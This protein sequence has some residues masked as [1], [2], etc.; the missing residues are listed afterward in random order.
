MSDKFR[1]WAWRAFLIVITVFGTLLSGCGGLRLITEEDAPTYSFD[2]NSKIYSNDYTL[3]EGPVKGGSANIYASGMDSLNPLMTQNMYTREIMNLIYEGL[4]EMDTGLTARPLLADSSERSEDGLTWKIYIKENIQWHDGTELTSADVLYTIKRIQAYGDDCVYAPLL[5]N[6]ANVIPDGK[7]AI[8]IRLKKVNSFTLE[9][10]IFPIIPSH[11]EPRDDILD[12]GTP[13][14]E[15]LIGTGPY[16][17]GNYLPNES[18]SLYFNEDVS[19]DGEGVAFGPPYIQEI[20]FI[21]IE[22]E[23]SVITEFQ[24][25]KLDGFFSRTVGFEHYRISSDMISRSFSER[26]FE[27]IAFNLNR[28]GLSKVVRNA[29]ARIIDREAIIRDVLDGNGIVADFPVQPENWL[30]EMCAQ[31]ISRDVKS[32]I[33]S[34]ENGGYRLDFDSYSRPTSQGEMPLKFELLVNSGKP[35]SVKTAEKIAEQLKENWIIVNIVKVDSEEM[36]KRIKN[37]S[38]DMVITSFRVGVFCDMSLMYSEPYFDSD[39]SINISGYQN[40]E[41]DALVNALFSDNDTAGR[42]NDFAKLTSMIDEDMPYIGLYFHFSTTFLRNEIKGFEKPHVWNPYGS[43][44][45]WYIADY[46]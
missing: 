20:K 12:D 2:V 28:P 33:E 1:G 7:Y 15:I 39:D 38:F 3:D 8:V 31:P 30:G 22:K 46:R 43:I 41:V 14:S 6:I 42:Q 9:T 44:R 37:G 19:V 36:K 29:I 11:I 40:E 25:G 21:F 17:A 24:S 4:Y 5:A 18:I 16:K 32:A 45:K 26:E 35:E 10:L 27:F 34:L 13:I 23:K